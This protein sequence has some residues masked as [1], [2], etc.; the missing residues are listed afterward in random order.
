MIMIPLNA[1]RLLRAV[2]SAGSPNFSS[3]SSRQITYKDKKVRAVLMLPSVDL[4]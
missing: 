2:L 4:E 1:R 3:H